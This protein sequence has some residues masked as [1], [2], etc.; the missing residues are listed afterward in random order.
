MTDPLDKFGPKPSAEKDAEYKR[1]REATIILINRMYSRFKRENIHP[2]A[3]LPVLLE[4]ALFGMLMLDLEM[5]K[6]QG[7]PFDF[8]RTQLVTNTVFGH[9]VAQFQQRQDEPQ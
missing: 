5:C 3:A 8:S 4:T 1:Q 9:C 6:A 7:K 2:A